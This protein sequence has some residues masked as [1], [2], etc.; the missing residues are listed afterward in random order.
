MRTRRPNIL[1]I[2]TD[3]QRYDTIAAL[4][5]P[6]IHTPNLDRLAEEGVAF[7]HATTPCPVSMP[8]RW[9]LLTGQ[10]PRT[11]G[12]RS[13]H[14]P[15]PVPE[16]HLPRLLSQV[17]Y[18]TALVGKNHSFLE[19][20]DL[21]FWEEDPQPEENTAVTERREWIEENAERYARLAA[22]A[23]PGGVEADPDHQKTSAAINIMA[24]G[25]EHPFFVWLSYVHPHTPYRVPEPF[26]SMYRDARLPGPFVEPDGLPNARK[27][28]RQRFHQRNNDR[29]LPFNEE[30]V[31][32]MR[33][34]YYGQV[35]F[36]DA[37]VGRVIEFLERSGLGRTTLVIFTSDHGDYMGDHGM[38]TK[39]PALYDC[40]V[41]VPFIVH[42]PGHIDAGR[43]DSR[44]VSLV[45][46][47]PTCADA[48][49]ARIPAEVQGF[50]LLPMLADGGQGDPVR[51]G[52]F[53]EYGVPGKPYNPARLRKEGLQD[54]VFWNPFG[55]PLPW[56]ANPVSL[57][58]I[59][60]MIRTREWKYVD[61][62]GGRCELYDLLKD[63]HELTNLAGLPALSAVETSLRATL[64]EWTST[65][66]ENQGAPD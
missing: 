53:S 54:K 27:P 51:L 49:G 24:E 42:W 4:G 6:H 8:A 38:F 5:N 30:D 60:Q 59:I 34:V 46:I 19:K 33:R 11:H 2:H 48:A 3:Q 43:V 52:A 62:P 13:N 29:A 35:S 63:P 65:I 64:S 66:P 7:S 14:H 58:G 12:C 37:E 31:A 20:D 10:F 9:S 25:S 28:F 57:A 41:R 56:E 55:E 39:S 17:G 23:V 50:S 36:I 1:L 16:F 40:L 18:R 21:F 45:D 22:E 32:M 47:L 26:F 61:D 15:G 44:F